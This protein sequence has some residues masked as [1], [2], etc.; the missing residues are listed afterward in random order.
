[1]AHR[2]LRGPENRRAYR[3]PRQSPKAAVRASTHQRR[4]PITLARLGAVDESHYI[5]ENRATEAGDRF[6]ALG[7]LFDPVTIRHLDRLV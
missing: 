4:A 5:F 3:R 6:D 2:G 1:M 7:S